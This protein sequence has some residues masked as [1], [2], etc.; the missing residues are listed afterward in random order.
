MLMLSIPLDIMLI[1]YPILTVLN[2]AIFWKTGKQR[3]GERFVAETR[4]GAKLE[5]S[6]KESFLAY[7]VTARDLLL[8]NS[9]LERY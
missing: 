8:K 2:I 1:G 5:F 3:R 7:L 9:S 6:D 4:K